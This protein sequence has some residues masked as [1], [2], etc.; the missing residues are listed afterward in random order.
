MKQSRFS[1]TSPAFARSLTFLILLGSPLYTFAFDGHEHKYIGDRALVEVLGESGNPSQFQLPVKTSNDP[2]SAVV[3]F[4]LTSDGVDLPLDQYQ[5]VSTN[6]LTTQ[7]ISSTETVVYKTSNRRTNWTGNPVVVRVGSPA[8]NEWFTFGDLVGIY[9]DYQKDVLCSPGNVPS[10]NFDPALKTT[11]LKE[12]MNEWP[13]RVGLNIGCLQDPMCVLFLNGALKNTDHFG[14]R[15]VEVYKYRHQMALKHIADAVRSNRA[16]SLWY[17]FHWMAASMH[18][19]TDLFASG[20]ILMDRAI[21]PIYDRLC[22]DEGTAASAPSD[23]LANLVFRTVWSGLASANIGSFHNFLGNLGVQVLN[24]YEPED[25]IW[26]A[27]GDGALYR[28]LFQTRDNGAIEDPLWKEGGARLGPDSLAG[29]QLERVVGAVKTS[30]RSLFRATRELT[31]VATSSAQD[32][33]VKRREIHNSKWFY[34]ALKE[35]PLR[36]ASACL[37]KE[38]TTDFPLPREKLNCFS[39]GKFSV[40]PHFWSV[41]AS[42]DLSDQIKIH[43]IVGP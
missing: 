19:L 35:I 23:S 28:T 30:I 10:C 3:K 20:H 16:T 31:A 7:I 34:A 17:A 26:I 29:S 15:A 22:A 24:G 4:R 13:T 8:S 5:R 37:P 41:Y 39:I 36:Y 32:F 1:R 11:V 25:K 21:D 42:T 43:E 14:T 9:S 2:S 12:H 18:Q 40:V 38:R 33:E 27:F 6:N